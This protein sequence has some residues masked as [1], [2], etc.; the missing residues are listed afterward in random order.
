MR[1]AFEQDV[2]WMLAF[3][4]KVI[5]YIV[6]LNLIVLPILWFLEILYLLILILVYEA[7][8]ISILGVLQILCSYIYR[9]ERY[10]PQHALI[11]WFDFR[12]FAE[13]KPEERQRYRQEGRIMITIGLTLCIAA[14]IV[15]FSSP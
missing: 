1:S 8:F 6:A 3:V 5:G 13:L 7:L 11:K 2:H 12:E 14:I 9:A 4:L 10:P 15:H